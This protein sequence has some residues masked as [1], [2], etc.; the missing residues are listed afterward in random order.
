MGVSV[1][2]AL[3]VLNWD[4]RSDFSRTCRRQLTG[5]ILRL[6]RVV[7]QPIYWVKL[8]ANHFSNQH[9][10]LEE[11]LMLDQEL[12]QLKVNLQRFDFLEYENAALKQ[13][14]NS[15]RQMGVGNFLLA[16]P[17]NLVIDKF[18]REFTLNQGQ[19]TGVYLGQPVLA[20]AGLVGQVI[21][22]QDHTSVV[23]S[24]TNQKSAVPVTVTRNG[25][26]AIVTGSNH[27]HLLELVGV[28]ETT[29]IKL[30][31]LLVTSKIGGTFPD[32]YQVGVV[33]KITANINSGG[34]KILVEPKVNFA[35][36]SYLLLP[37]RT[38]ASTSR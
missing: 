33:K 6:Q 25:V 9:R 7:N 38:E 30:G 29:D 12:L 24:I 36:S 14:M 27:K 3:L 15:G 32:G 23:M 28:T 1:L 2:V 8:L 17:L 22:I 4:I 37:Q 26:K 19:K 35:T 20:A 16:E 18:D 10:L 34:L 11:N 21:S 13:L 5:P 31:D